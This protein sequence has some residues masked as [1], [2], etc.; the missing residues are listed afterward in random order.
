[1]VFQGFGLKINFFSIMNII[2]IQK[3][4]KK[5]IIRKDF[6]IGDEY[7]SLILFLEIVARGY[8]RLLIMVKSLV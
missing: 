1:M 4:S 7:H 6:I 3:N 5:K 8:I 2:T